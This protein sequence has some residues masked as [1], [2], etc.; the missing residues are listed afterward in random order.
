MSRASLILKFNWSTLSAGESES[1]SNMTKYCVVSKKWYWRC[2]ARGHDGSFQAPGGSTE[3]LEAGV[4]RLRVAGQVLQTVVAET[5]QVTKAKTNTIIVTNTIM[6]TN[7]I[8]VTNKNTN[9]KTIKGRNTKTP[10]LKVLKTV[11]AQPLQKNL[12]LIYQLQVV[13]EQTKKWP[14]WITVL[15]FYSMP[16]KKSFCK[17][18]LLCQD[19]CRTICQVSA[20]KLLPNPFAGQLC[21]KNPWSEAR[22]SRIIFLFCKIRSQE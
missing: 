18:S 15:W 3:K 7:T 9:T 6:E 2:S 12:K 14:N 4:K 22:N 20:L 17:K 1:D 21:T 8:M 16:R 5:M 11:V 19:F 13:C 10:P